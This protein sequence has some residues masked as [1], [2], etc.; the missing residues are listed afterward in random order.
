[1]T[2]ASEA[3]R[4]ESSPPSTVRTR[5]IPVEELIGRAVEPEI[6]DRAEASHGEIDDVGDVAAFADEALDSFLDIPAPPEG[7]MLPPARVDSP[8][9]TPALS[10]EPEPAPLAGLEPAALDAALDPSTY[11]GS[12]AELVDR[13][14][15]FYERSQRPIEVDP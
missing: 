6:Q 5:E 1:M 2:L 10:A 8:L 11:L 4:S 7:S 14:L 12:A 3:A 9:V 15:A 13:A